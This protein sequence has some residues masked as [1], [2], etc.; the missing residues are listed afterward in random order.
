MFS[1]SGRPCGRGYQFSG[2]GDQSD[3]KREASQVMTEHRTYPQ[4]KV[5]Q[6]TITIE[7]NPPA[8]C[9]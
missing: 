8:S 4:L 2:R 3:F 7:G 5:Q 1:A 9:E 6:P